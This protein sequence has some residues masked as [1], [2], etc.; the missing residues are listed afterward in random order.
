MAGSGTGG[1][2]TRAQIFVDALNE[3]HL[4]VSLG[5]CAEAHFIQRCLVCACM[6]VPRLPV[7]DGGSVGTRTWREQRH[8][9]CLVSLN[10]TCELRGLVVGKLAGLDLANLR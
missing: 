8:R 6:L 5:L 3:V 2:P 1:D 9:V 10:A 7:V 4:R